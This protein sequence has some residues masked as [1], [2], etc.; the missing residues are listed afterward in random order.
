MK[1]PAPRS[2]GVPEEDPEVPAHAQ[3]PQTAPTTH[4][5]PWQVFS[6]HFPLPSPGWQHWDSPGAA[7]AESSS[8]L[9]LLSFLM[10]RAAEER[11][12]RTGRHRGSIQAAE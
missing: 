11:A 1:E 9:A 4:Y 10:N 7:S 5:I 8:F 12:E 3:P 2:R 6:P